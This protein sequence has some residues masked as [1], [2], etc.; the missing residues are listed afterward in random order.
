[1]S[2]WLETWAETCSDVVSG[3]SEGTADEVAVEP[4]LVTA[5]V[6][7][8]ARDPR[9]VRIGVRRLADAEWGRLRAAVESNPGVVAALRADE[10]PSELVDVAEAAGVALVPRSNDVA[11]ECSCG[12]WDDRC[13]HVAVV[14]A[15]L[16]ARMELD[17]AVLLSLRDGHPGRLGVEAAPLADLDAVDVGVSASARWRR[18][19]SPLPEVDTSALVPRPLALSMAP[20]AESGLVVGDLHRLVLDAAGRA[21]AFLDGMAS[22]GLEHDAETD[23][24]R[25]ACAGGTVALAGLAASAGIEPVDLERQMI[26][27]TV[28]GPDGLAADRQ[29]WVAPDGALAPGIR[30]LGGPEVTRARGDRVTRTDGAVQ[31]RLARDSQ[32]WAFKVDADLGWVLAGLSA[33]D[34]S[35]LPVPPPTVDQP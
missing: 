21:T 27:W 6:Y 4:G 31:L 16:G 19:P 33:T 13:G 15:A 9:R 17:P 7:G 8:R 34:P 12:S 1:M 29:R 5:L 35:D 14:L 24:V 25:R 22:T 30:A 3:R 20:P 18:S 28:A 2:E 10:V 23:I 26:A 11:P 32:W